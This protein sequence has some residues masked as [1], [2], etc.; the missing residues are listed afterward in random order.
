M[1]PCLRKWRHAIRVGFEVLKVHAIHSQ[2]VRQSVSLSV[3]ALDSLYFFTGRHDELGLPPRLGV[4]NVFS[5]C[6]L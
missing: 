1:W 2:S 5:N 3:Y 4:L 6:F